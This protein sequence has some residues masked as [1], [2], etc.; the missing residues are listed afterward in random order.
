VLSGLD[1]RESSTNP[2]APSWI[3]CLL[4]IATIVASLRWRGFAATLRSAGRLAKPRTPGAPPST[5]FVDATA[6]AVAIAGALF[7][8]RAVCLEQSLA[9]LI[10]L[11]RS[12]APVSLRVGVQPYRFRA[13]AW[14][15]CDGVPVNE[16]GELIRGLVLLPD[17]T[18]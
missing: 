17:I 18:G 1:I 13:H 14:I 15:E 3:Y 12:G 16:R 9:L 8:G 7:P 5:A 6:R 2:H 4:L 11:G 10:L